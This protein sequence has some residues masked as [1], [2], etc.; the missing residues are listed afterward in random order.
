MKQS[1][2]NIS[3]RWVKDHISIVDLLTNMG[4]PPPK[5]TGKERYYHS[6]LRDDPTPS[7]CVDEKQNIWHDHGEGKGGTIIDFAM[8]IWKDLSFPELLEKIVAVSQA[9]GPAQQPYQRQQVARSTPGYGIL[10]VKHLGQNIALLEYL[11]RRGISAVADGRIREVHYYTE[12]ANKFRTNFFAAGWQNELG[13]W[14]VSSI[15]RKKLCLG[16]KAISFIP[17]AERR[18]AVFEGFF[19]YLSW[20][21]DNPFATDSVLVLNSVALLEA[22]LKKAEPFSE[23]FLFLDNDPTGQRATSAFRQAMPRAIDCSGIYTGYNDY[24]DK[25]VAE[26]GGYRLSR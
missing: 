16:P 20:L 9:Q 11:E 25:I 19:N 7:F 18:L 4:Y 21:T 1:S 22:G 2:N 15:D 17:N 26:R 6:P 14:E 12:N 3:A 8:L 23:I 24:N 13:V 10:A 5:P